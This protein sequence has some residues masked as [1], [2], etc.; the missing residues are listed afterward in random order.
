MSHLKVATL[1]KD[2]C[3][4]GLLVIKEREREMG[5]EKEKSGEKEI[6]GGGGGGRWTARGKWMGEKD[7]TRLT[8]GHGIL[9]TQ[10]SNLPR[11]VELGISGAEDFVNSYS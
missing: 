10:R 1:T 7:K 5:R 6:G 2:N 9:G 8:V 11:E 4:A 3:P